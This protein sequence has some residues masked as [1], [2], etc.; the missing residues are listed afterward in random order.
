[1]SREILLNHTE[2]RDYCSIWTDTLPGGETQLVNTNKLL[3]S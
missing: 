1:M 3:K 2:V